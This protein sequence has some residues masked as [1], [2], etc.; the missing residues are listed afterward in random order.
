[1]I[2]YHDNGETPLLREYFIASGAE[3][4]PLYR[5]YPLR[6]LYRKCRTHLPKKLVF[7][8]PAPR[9]EDDKIIVFDTLVTQPYLTWLC[10]RFPDRRIIFWYWNP[11]GGDRKFELF[12][13]RVEIWSYSPEDCK[14]YGFRRNTQF[15]FD[16][17]AR[18]AEGTGKRPVSSDPV[19][20]FLGR[21]KGRRE[22]LEKLRAR[23]EDAGADVRIQLKRDG[24]KGTRKNAPVMPYSEVIREIAGC[25]IVLDYALNTDEGLSL[26][27]ME[28]L[29]FGKKLITNNETVMRYDFYREEN[30]Y[31]LNRDRR[32]L[33]EFFETEYAEP[34][35]AVKERYLFSHW[36]ERF[37]DPEKDAE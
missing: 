21:E 35:R 13:R 1:M 12:P 28:A 24:T 4:T 7:H 5:N 27:P 32:T 30:I 18:D 26:R 23:L 31:V 34:D 37:D 14:R 20:L 8:T 25:D 22:E 29:F 36:L 33:K 9:P 16:S 6:Y 2:I 3:Y 11:V 17:V 15:Y 10:E 19:V